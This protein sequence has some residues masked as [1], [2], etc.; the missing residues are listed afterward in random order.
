METSLIE[1][2]SYPKLGPGELWDVT[3][4]EIEKLGAGRFGAAAVLRSFIRMKI[5]ISLP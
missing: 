5:I 1:E 2:F 4:S 3:G